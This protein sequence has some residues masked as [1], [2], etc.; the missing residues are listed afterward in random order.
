MIKE[1]F[2]K[3]VFETVIQFIFILITFALVVF[4]SIGLDFNFEK[5][6]T[7]TYWVEVTLKLMLALVVF[8]GVKAMDLIN[9][10]HKKNSRFFKAFAT[11]SLRRAY[12]EDHKLYKELD[13]AVLLENKR[14]LIRT[15]NYALHEICTRISYEDV[16]DSKEVENKTIEELMEEFRVN[17]KRKKDFKKLV[18]KIRAGEIK[19][20]KVRS[21]IFLRDKELSKFKFDKLDYS[22]A[23]ENIKS[24]I[25][26]MMTFLICTIILTIIGFSAVNNNFWEIFLTNA[27]LLFTSMISGM[28][29]SATLIKL[30]TEIYEKRNA[31]IS[32]YMDINIVYGEEK[33]PEPVKEEQSVE[34]KITN[35]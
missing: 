10:I 29:N 25:S 8:N 6:Y 20:E 19:F 27:F 7:A 35:E 16:V 22:V 1:K 11:N 14:R 9:R 15:C 4:I 31:F 24:N 18:N 21:E 23:G 12:I 17:K 5:L 26:K 3:A 33:Q 13:D 2:P 34:E 28:N 30:K 32:R